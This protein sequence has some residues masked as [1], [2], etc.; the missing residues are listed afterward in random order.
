MVFG[1]GKKKKKK[2]ILMSPRPKKKKPTQEGPLNNIPI[3]CVNNVQDN[4]QEVPPEPLLQGVQTEPTQDNNQYNDTD[5]HIL[6]TDNNILFPNF[7]KDNQVERLPIAHAYRFIFS[8][9]TPDEWDGVNGTLSKVCQMFG[10][11]ANKEM[12]RKIQRF[13]L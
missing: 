3:N 5:N 8:A 10:W 2:S 4:D 6:T 9:P 13:F 11:E 1:D 12:K 7:K